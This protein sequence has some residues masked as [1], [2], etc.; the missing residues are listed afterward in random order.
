[1]GVAVFVQNITPFEVAA[2]VRYRPRLC[3]KS[4]LFMYKINAIRFIFGGLDR[5]EI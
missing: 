4:L 1:M 5:G 3:G 2:P